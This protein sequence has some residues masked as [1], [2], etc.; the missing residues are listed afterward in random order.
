MTLFCRPLEFDSPEYD[1][2][3]RLREDVLRKPLGMKLRLQ[4]QRGEQAQ[5]HFGAF[6]DGKLMGV[7]IFVPE[8]KPNAKLRQM[9]IAPSQ[10]GKG[11]GAKLLECVHAFAKAQGYS[12]LTLN[13]RETARAFY[14]KNGYAPFGAPFTEVG[15]PHVAMK[16]DL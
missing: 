6:D 15:I 14:A 9:A 12:T 4:D 2:S 3:L 11:V 7:I 13:A 1:A 16:I 5:L 8:E 10:Q